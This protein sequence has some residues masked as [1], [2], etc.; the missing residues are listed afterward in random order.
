MP[1]NIGGALVLVVAQT[2]KNWKDAGQTVMYHRELIR[3]CSEEN[4][5]G[6]FM[7]AFEKELAGILCNDAQY[8]RAVN[9][10]VVPSLV[11]VLSNRM[12]GDRLE[13]V[14]LLLDE[15]LSAY[16]FELQG[17][18]IESEVFKSHLEVVV[19][20]D[21]VLSPD[22][23]VL[24]ENILEGYEGEELLSVKNLITEITK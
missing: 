15:V 2:D 10:H 13:A 7:K 9:N 3:A 4:R 1:Y 14:S 5:K 22:I 20:I 24:T 19:L 8:Q 12:D 17:R 23:R 6:A 11:R 16:S 21:K 18:N